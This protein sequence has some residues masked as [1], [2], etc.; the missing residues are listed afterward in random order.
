MT[1]FP[2]PAALSHPRS[3]RPGSDPPTAGLSWSGFGSSL[4]RGSGSDQEDDGE[5]DLRDINVEYDEEGA[6]EIVPR[7][8]PGPQGVV[9]LCRGLSPDDERATMFT[10]TI[11]I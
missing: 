6:E 9:G 3:A 10:I 11:V 4:P 8:R 2:P 7:R 5:V 1:F